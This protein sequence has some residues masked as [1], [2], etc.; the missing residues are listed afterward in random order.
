VTIRQATALALLAALD[1]G[2]AHVN[3]PEARGAA[4]AMAQVISR[5]KVDDGLLGRAIF[6]ETN[7]VRAARGLRPLAPSPALDSAADEQA[8]FMAL[9]CRAEHGN[10]FPGEETVAER[11]ARA[12]L[13][14]SRVAENALMIPA[15]PP[16]G[17]PQPDYTYA[18]LADRLVDNW[19]N[20]PVHRAILLD[21]GYT[22]L[23]C[24]ARIGRGVAAGDRQVFATQVFFLP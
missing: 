15:Q 23:G 5:A 21:P 12:G 4:G 3:P 16:P 6:A 24:A 9:M 22:L 17:S 8:M 2:C 7:R 11:V 18:A 13:S 14:G 19:M 20:S 10:P 1:A